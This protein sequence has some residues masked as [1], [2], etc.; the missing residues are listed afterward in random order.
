MSIFRSLPVKLLVKIGNGKMQILRLTTPKLHPKEQ[1]SLFGGPGT[2]K[3]LGPLS[4]S[5][6]SASCGM[7]LAVVELIS[8]TGH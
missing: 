1:R 5:D 3:R 2:E 7:T 8:D 4:L 6:D